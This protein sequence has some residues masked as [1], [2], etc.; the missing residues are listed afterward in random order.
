MNFSD[1]KFF[2]VIAVIGVIV[3]SVAYPW[4]WRR[5]PWAHREVPR[6]NYIIVPK[7]YPGAKPLDQLRDKELPSLSHPS[8]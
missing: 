5:Y 8:T 3:Y 1:C 2:L 7:D 6:P 4:G